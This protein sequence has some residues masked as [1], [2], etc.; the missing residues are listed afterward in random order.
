[1]Q[2]GASPEAH[3]G[4]AQDGGCAGAKEIFD[5]TNTSHLLRKL[6]AFRHFP[7]I[8][9]LR[10]FPNDRGW[11][12][13]HLYCVAM[14]EKQNRTGSCAGI[15]NRILRSSG[16]RNKI[17]RLNM[18]FT[19]P[20]AGSAKLGWRA[21]TLIELLVVIAIIGILASMLLPALGKGKQKARITQC[22][23]NLHQIG[24]GMAMYTHD[25]HDT[26]P[27]SYAVDTNNNLAGDTF[28]SIGGKDPRSDVADSLPPAYARPLFPYLQAVEL[29][30][31][32][33]DHGVLVPVK[34]LPITV[35]L[36]PS[37]W[38]VAGCSY[39]YNTGTPWGH[40]RTRLPEAETLAGSK[41]GSITDPSRF[42]LMHE[43]PARSFKIRLNWDNSHVYQH[44]HY[45]APSSWYNLPNGVDTPQPYLDGDGRKFVSPNLF[46]DGHVAN[47]D[48]TSTIHADPDY[49]FEETR[50]WIWYKPV[51][52]PKVAAL[53]R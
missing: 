26:F 47:H 3:I 52:E 37:C 31:C 5:S 51:V 32:P 35:L 16:N 13:C 45:A 28:T 18:Q 38:D 8:A 27:R 1:M 30:H 41:V 10:S 33:E 17:E 22:L 39:M 53:S 50:N 11:S 36:K 7:N 49:V 14:V 15:G 40:D 4:D 29:F 23:N 25:Q 21:F 48:F 46:V 9:L 20:Q 34:T 19:L 43:P 12:A 42:I 6:R 24:T 44:W 2:G